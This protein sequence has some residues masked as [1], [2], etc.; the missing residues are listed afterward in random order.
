MR[1][2]HANQTLKSGFFMALSAAPSQRFFFLSPQTSERSRSGCRSEAEPS[3]GEGP[4]RRGRLSLS[5]QYP[6][7]LAFDREC[8]A[9]TAG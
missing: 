4:S 2:P 7:A 9:G 6:F 5:C 1:G 8:R 3:P